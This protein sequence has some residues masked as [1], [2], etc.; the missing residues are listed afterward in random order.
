MTHCVNAGSEVGKRG[1]DRVSQ[2]DT[3]YPMYIVK[4]MKT[5]HSLRVSIPRNVQ[6]HLRV[7]VGDYIRI[8]TLDG[9]GARMRKLDYEEIRR[10]AIPR[11]PA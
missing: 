1:V 10:A 3:V 4:C 7:R 9:G 6:R 2:S 8:D 11:D 5:G